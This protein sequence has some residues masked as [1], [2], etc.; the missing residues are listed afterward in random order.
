MS[1]GGGGRRRRRKGRKKANKLHKTELHAY[2]EPLAVQYYRS[3]P[4]AE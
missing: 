1:Y 3:R 4:W 2:A